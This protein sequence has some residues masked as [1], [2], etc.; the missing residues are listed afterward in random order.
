[1]ILQ[2]LGVLSD[3]IYCNIKNLPEFLFGNTILTKNPLTAYILSKHGH[4]AVSV[5]GEIFFPH[6]SVMQFD[7]GSTISDF[8]K[9]ILLSDSVESLKNNIE[10]LKTLTKLRKIR[11]TQYNYGRKNNK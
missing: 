8:T 10:K 5:T 7:Y 2:Y 4:K 11:K 6:L 3:F 9:D 1:M